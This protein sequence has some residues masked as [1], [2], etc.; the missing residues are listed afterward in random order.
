[1]RIKIGLVGTSQK[2]FPGPKEQEYEKIVHQM[3]LN[4]A[5]M[6]FD[7]VYY[8]EQVIVEDDAR[9]AVKFMESEGVD[10]LLILNISYSAGFLVPIFYRIKNAAVGIWAIPEPRE[11]VVMFNSFCSNN[12]YQGINA[13]YLTDYKIKSKWFFG[14]ADDERF[15]RRLS[16][17]VK[18]LQAIKKLRN[19]RVALIGGFAPGFYD[20]YF[21]ERSV[22]SKL[23][24]IYI[25]RLHEYDEIIKLAEKVSDKD[26]MPYLEET[27]KAGIQKTPNAKNLYPFSL[28]LYLAYKRLVE[29]NGYDAIAVSCWPK[30]QDDYKYSVCSTLGMLNDDKIVAACEGDL[31]SAISMLAL[32]EMSDDSTTL[33]DFGAFDED[34]DSL[35][36]WHCGPSS[37]R[38]CERNGYRLGDNYSGMEHPK[39][40]IVGTGVVRDMV[41]D[42]GDAT[43]FRFSGDMDGYLNLT[44]RFVGTDKPSPCGSRGWLKDIR[45]N[46]K[47]ISAIDFTNTILSGGFEH[48]YAISWGNLSDEVAEMNK[49]LGIKPVRKISYENYLQDSED[50]E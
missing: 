35:L 32:Q 27:D 24:G 5:E 31:M 10:L 18:A 9:K 34:D 16:V 6:K 4:S 17:T 50:Q 1:M 15:K 14:Y 40:K 11:G 8:P 25:N 45:L 7:F 49:W 36:M 3:Q 2:S 39:G 44:G 46:G 26:I 21:D 41:F 30:F 47:K 33:M 37:K 28:K 12:M 13:K 43:V 38:F 19:S 23:D 20:L 29:E 42:P 48:H 22:F